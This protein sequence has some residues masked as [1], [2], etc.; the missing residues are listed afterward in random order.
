MKRIF[1]TIVS[2]LVITSCLGSDLEESVEGPWVL[3][4]GVIDDEPI[5]VH[6]THP[7]TMQLEGGRLTGTAACNGYQG[8]Y[9]IDGADFEIVEGVTV[10]EMACIPEEIMRNEGLFLDAL[11]RADEITLDRE[12]LTLSGTGITL[13]FAPSAG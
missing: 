3:T 11:L 12:R 10:T 8:G 6:A 13:V 2:L 5:Q 1:L 4:S 7:V 9:R